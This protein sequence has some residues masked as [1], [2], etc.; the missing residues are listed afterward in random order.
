VWIER[1]KRGGQ[2]RGLKRGQLTLSMGPARM[3]YASSYKEPLFQVRD[4]FFIFAFISATHAIICL[5]GCMIK[6]TAYSLL[7]KLKI[8]H[9]TENRN[10]HL[11][12]AQW[13]V[14]G[15]NNHDEMI[16]IK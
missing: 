15:C 3:E 1:R 2:A 13:V 9:V 12:L 4:Y 11:F 6:T 8:N 7:Y 10:M 16:A 14:Y 5:L